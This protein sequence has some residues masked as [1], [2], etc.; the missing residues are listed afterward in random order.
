MVEDGMTE[1]A[2]R[3]LTD[4]TWDA[5]AALCARHNGGGFGGCWCTAFHNETSA[6]RRAAVDAIP[7]PEGADRASMCREYK[8]R[9]VYEGGAHAALVFDG[10]EAIGWCQYGS[11]AELPGITHRKEVESAGEPMPDYRLG[12]FFVDRRYRRKG[13]AKAALDG[14]LSLIAAAGGGVVE[15]YPFDTTGKKVSASFLYNATRSMCERA[16]FTYER[17]KGK[18]HCVMRQVVE[19][20][21]SHDPPRV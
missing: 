13:V 10:D 8:K 14:A 19:P 18:N 3:P 17:P 5:F 20:S 12:C 1:Y 16:G 9:L 2:I 6:E 15:A 11:P 4:Q 21:G 7:A